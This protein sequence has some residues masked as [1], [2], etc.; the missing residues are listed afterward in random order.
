MNV[1]K[2]EKRRVFHVLIMNYRQMKPKPLFFSIYLIKEKNRIKYK[3]IIIPDGFLQPWLYSSSLYIAWQSKY[4]F[5]DDVFLM[6][7]EVRFRSEKS[8]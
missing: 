2:T 8:N 6:F 4:T 5:L 7:K 3:H 1:W